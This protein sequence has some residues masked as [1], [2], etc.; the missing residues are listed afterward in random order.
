MNWGIWC[1]VSKRH[2]IHSDL[3]WNI[4]LL[5]GSWMMKIEQKELWISENLFHSSL[6]VHKTWQRLIST[7]FNCISLELFSIFS[8]I[9][10]FFSYVLFSYRWKQLITIAVNYWYEV[11]YHVSYRMQWKKL[12][13]LN[14]IAS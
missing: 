8:V 11:N 13:E 3:K 6:P 2:L 1:C 10:S 7:H 4:I 5:P 14:M 9:M 12:H